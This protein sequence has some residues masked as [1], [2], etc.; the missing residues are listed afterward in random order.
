M[1]RK[2]VGEMELR[3]MLRI[4]NAPDDAA[5]DGEPLPQSVLAALSQLFRADQVHFMRLDVERQEVPLYQE[6]G[7]IGDVEAPV[8]VFGRATGPRR[9]LV[10]RS[11]RATSPVSSRC[12]TSAPA[13]PT[14]HWL[15]SDYSA[16]S[17]CTAR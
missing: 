6:Y 4:V 9:L 1:A 7:Q 11:Y 13:P 10:S 2:A 14:R 8:D 17:G 16:C 12:P 15:W 5:A 3:T